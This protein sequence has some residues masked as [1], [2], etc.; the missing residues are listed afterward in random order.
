MSHVQDIF[1][2]LLEYESDIMAG[3]F[4]PSDIITVI[5]SVNPILEVCFCF[6]IVLTVLFFKVQ[7]VFFFR[8]LVGSVYKLTRLHGGEGLHEEKIFTF[9]IK[10]FNEIKC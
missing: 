8:V 3:N 2:A 9:S 1:E 7:M 6:Y 10:K 4:T 5:A